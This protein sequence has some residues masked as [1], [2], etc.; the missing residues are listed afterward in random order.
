MIKTELIIKSKTITPKSIFEACTTKK[1]EEKKVKNLVRIQTIL[2]HSL[3]SKK[4]NSTQKLF[5]L[6]CDLIFVWPC[7][8]VVRKLRSKK[9]L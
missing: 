3:K 4:R 9:Q 8:A 5:F 6:A 2:L 1:E 7:T